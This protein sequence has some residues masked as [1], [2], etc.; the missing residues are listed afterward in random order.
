[1]P[2]RPPRRAAP[3]PPW[4]VVRCAAA[5]VH[6]VYIPAAVVGLAGALAGRARPPARPRSPLI[7]ASLTVV[8]GLLGLLDAIIPERSQTLLAHLAP[9]VHPLARSLE[10]PSARALLYVAVLSLLSGLV[11]LLAAR[12]TPR[13][14]RP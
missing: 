7:L 13:T 1:M 6:A 11:V 5:A 3:R 8:A 9:G 14:V 12:L 10:G 2:R 4:P